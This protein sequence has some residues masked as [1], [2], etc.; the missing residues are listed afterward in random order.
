MNLRRLFIFKD[1]FSIKDL[2][3]IFE[4]KEYIEQ[5]S[6]A[7]E[8]ARYWI[9]LIGLFTGVRLGEICQLHI[10]DIKKSSGVWFFDINSD[11]EDKKLKNLSSKRQI[12]IH[13]VLIDL[14]FLDLIK[15]LEEKKQIRV[16]SELVG[17]RD[18]YTK[19]ISRWLN[20]DYLI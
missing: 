6:K 9:P 16:F 2:Q 14:G 10:S 11:S 1:R 4:P 8:N 5:T 7:K 17:G 20:Q 19:Y 3:K 12:P 13:P 15:S 18:G